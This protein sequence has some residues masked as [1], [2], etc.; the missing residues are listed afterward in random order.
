MNSAICLECYRAFLIPICLDL[1]LFCCVVRKAFFIGLCIFLSLLEGL[2]SAEEFC[3]SEMARLI[4]GKDYPDTTKSPAT[5][6]PQQY[7][8]GL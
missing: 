3:I 6:T 4:F 5:S 8:R 7:G 2:S 1:S